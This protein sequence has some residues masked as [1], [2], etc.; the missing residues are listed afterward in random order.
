ML[1]VQDVGKIADN[2]VAMITLKLLMKLGG[3]ILY[4]PVF[5]IPS[6]VFSIAG[7]Y[8]GTIY[9]KAQMSV[10][11]EMSNAKSPVISVFSSAIGGLGML[12]RLLHWLI[13]P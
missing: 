12:L 3:I 7:G 4:I 6:I 8:L 13:V 1:C 11:R 10:K 9:L 2:H 5:I